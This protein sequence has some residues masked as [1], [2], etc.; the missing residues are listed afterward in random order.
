MKNKRGLS[1]T[2]IIVSLIVIVVVVLLLAATITSFMNSKKGEGAKDVGSSLN[3]FFDNSKSFVFGVFKYAGF[4]Q[5]DL[6]SWEHLGTLVI[7]VLASALFPILLG[8]LNKIISTLEKSRKKKV[9]LLEG[10]W[11]KFGATIFILLIIHLFVT[12]VP[13]MKIFQPIL[14]P[15]YSDYGLQATG[16]LQS[17]VNPILSIFQQQQ[18]NVNNNQWFLLFILRTLLLSVWILI[19][20]M[21]L[22]LAPL[23]IKII[24]E[25]ILAYNKLVKKPL[26]EEKA[27]QGAREFLIGGQLIQGIGRQAARGR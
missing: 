11:A 8:I 16:S 22:K 19:P 12:F 18:Y 17:L 7:I 21:I 26:E 14:L 6:F 25:P 13:F 15:L 20:F 4:N 27:N 2:G 23:I 5:M 1:W 9:A 3:S 24:S 10:Y